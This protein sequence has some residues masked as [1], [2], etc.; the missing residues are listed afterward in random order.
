MILQRP[1]PMP[2]SE[3]IRP[4]P[5]QVPGLHLALALDLDRSSSPQANS[6][7]SSSYVER[8]I[9]NSRACSWPPSDSPY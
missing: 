9:W 6:S 7:F 4:R 3:A 8:V 5:D 2:R 1:P